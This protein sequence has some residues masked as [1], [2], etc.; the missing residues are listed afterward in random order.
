MSRQVTAFYNA[1]AITISE[2]DNN[3]IIRNNDS[4]ETRI[5]IN[6]CLVDIK[7]RDPVPLPAVKFVD[8]NIQTT[9][10]K[11]QSSAFNCR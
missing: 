9:A 1:H 5:I 7:A 8:I 11:I 2:H 3:S 10:H 4:S 6:L